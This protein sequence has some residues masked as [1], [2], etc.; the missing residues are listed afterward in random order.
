[1]IFVK[2]LTNENVERA[3]RAIVSEDDGKWLSVYGA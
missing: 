3:L 1:M 2:R